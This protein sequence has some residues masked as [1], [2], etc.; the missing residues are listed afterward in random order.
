MAG[1]EGVVGD[2]IRARD[3]SEQAERLVEAAVLLGIAGEKGVPGYGVSAGHGVEHLEGGA[4]VAAADVSGDSLVGGMDGEWESHGAET[5][6][7]R[8]V[9]FRTSSI[10]LCWSG[11]AGEDHS[12]S[13]F[14]LD[15][16]SHANQNQ[17]ML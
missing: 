15:Q 13:T 4:E 1:E 14:L 17:Q 16:I 11:P 5:M 8:G 9:Q 2:D 3:P 10:S 7:K 12:N 6:P